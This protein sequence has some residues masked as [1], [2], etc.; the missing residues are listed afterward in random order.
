[1]GDKCP[2]PHSKV[3]A[4]AQSE[5]SQAGAGDESNPGDAT[6]KRGRSRG[7]RRSSTPAKSESTLICM[8]ES[9]GSAM[10][11]RTHQWIVD[12]GSSYDLVGEAA[13]TAEDKGK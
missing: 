4:P 5:D 8:E 1:M 6:Q 10:L 11:A 7:R 12:S 9:G 3:A 13:L 2:C